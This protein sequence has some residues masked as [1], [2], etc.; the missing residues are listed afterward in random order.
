[1]FQ[2]IEQEERDDPSEPLDYHGH[3]IYPTHHCVPADVDE[4]SGDP[5]ITDFGNA[6]P[7]RDWHRGWGVNALCRAP[8]ML[9]GLP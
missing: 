4:I 5:I 3:H 7:A 6:L 1:M 8:E 2:R 9:L